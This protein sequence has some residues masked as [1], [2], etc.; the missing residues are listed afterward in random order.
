MV[1][2]SRIELEITEYESVVI[3][4]SLHCHYKQEVTYNAIYFLKVCG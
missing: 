3:T 2:M 1:A 4:F